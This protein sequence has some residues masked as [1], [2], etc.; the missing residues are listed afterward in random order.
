VDSTHQYEMSLKKD[1]LFINL[2]SDDVYFI[3][4]QMDK[5]FRIMLDDSYV[6]VSAP[7]RKPP[8]EA[9]PPAPVPAPLPAVEAPAVV[10]NPEPPPPPALDPMNSSASSSVPVPEPLLPN[11]PI[12]AA[13][14]EITPHAAHP[15][16]VDKVASAQSPS[17]AMAPPEPIPPSL[18]LPE[19]TPVEL[20]MMPAS[21]A[22]PVTEIDLVI[23][24]APPS[25]HE[26]LAAQ[27]AEISAQAISPA[28]VLVSESALPAAPILSAGV[29]VDDFEAIMNTVMQDLDEEA[30]PESAV[31]AEDLL[32][33][34]SVASLSDLCDRSTAQ[35]THDYLLLAAYYLTT[36]DHQKT[37]SLKQL[38]SSLVKAGQSPVNHSTLETALQQGVLTMVPDLTGTAEVSEY[39]LSDLGSATALNLF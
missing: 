21:I 5:W 9:T 27:Q 18:P 17:A 32:P 26:R 38:N 23:P 19:L 37:F 4:R 6:P 11:Q 28:L 20:P 31:A 24:M 35:S 7:K 34:E 30:M 39:R 29:P 13:G 12:S 3:S 10:Y 14:P 1:G 36:F 2:S 16:E 15:A 8:V 22:P 33:M 25:I